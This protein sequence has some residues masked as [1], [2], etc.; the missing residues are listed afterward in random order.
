M[1]PGRQHRRLPG[2]GI[3]PAR[4]PPA[5][6]RSKPPRLP[7]AIIEQSGAAPDGGAGTPARRSPA[8]RPKQNARATHTSR[9]NLGGV[10]P[11]PHRG[12][13]EH[14][15]CSRD[16]PAN[17]WI[18]GPTGPGHSG[19]PGGRRA[20]HLSWPATIRLRRTPAAGTAV[21]TRWHTTAGPTTRERD[22]RERCCGKSK[23][24]HCHERQR[25]LSSC[26]D[27]RI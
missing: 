5:S 6:R 15:G 20:A 2:I 21:S 13:P 3:Q 25:G 14:P 24:P 9:T 4:G 8:M 19:C 26:R 10:S 7:T 1:Y 12:T 23:S 18:P 22:G 27:D 16:G 17:G 11:V